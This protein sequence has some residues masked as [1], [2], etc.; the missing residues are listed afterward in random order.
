MRRVDT[1]PQ[2]RQDGWV[3]HVSHQKVKVHVELNPAALEYI[4]D[5]CDVN[6]NARSI[7]KDNVCNEEDNTLEMDVNKVSE[8]DDEEE[9][10]NNELSSS[11]SD[12]EFT[13]DHVM[14]K[15]GVE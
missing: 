8:S 3:E 14:Q 10:E 6:P 1:G 9:W 13:L 4:L 12:D 2:R 5:D 15:W 7:F 11:T